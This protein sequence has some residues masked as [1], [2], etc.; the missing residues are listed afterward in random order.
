MELIGQALTLLS[1]L[2][3]FAVGLGAVA[4]VVLYVVDVTQT[5]HAVRRN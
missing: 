1:G 2:F 3:V 5:R 4:V